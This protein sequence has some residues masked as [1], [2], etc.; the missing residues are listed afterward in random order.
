MISTELWSCVAIGNLH[1]FLPELPPPTRGMDVAETDLKSVLVFFL[2]ITLC[3]YFCGS[4]KAFTIACL[5]D[6]LGLVDQI[7][8]RTCITIIGGR[9]VLARI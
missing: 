4:L 8:E 9:Y 5:V 7:F 1:F 2:R 3:L 6:N